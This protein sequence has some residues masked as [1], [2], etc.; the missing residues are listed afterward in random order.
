VLSGK[1]QFGIGASELALRRA[2]GAPIV[3]LAT[4][5]QHSP[6]VLLVARG[7][8]DTVQGLAGKRIMLMPHE[9]ELYAYLQREGVPRGSFTEVRHSFVPADLIEGRVDA[10]SGYSTD[11]PWNLQQAGFAYNVFTPRAS[12]VDFYG[13]TLFTTEAVAGRDRARAEAFRA[14]SLRGWQYAMQHPPEIAD[15]ILARY[16]RRHPREHL[17]F[18]AEEM[19]RLMQPQL[20]EI[21]HMNPG[22]WQHIAEVYAELGMLPA[23]WTLDGF[24]WEPRPRFDLD[25]MLRLLAGSLLIA[26]VVAYFALRQVRFN[27]SLR[28]VNER[29]QHQLKEIQDLHALLEQQLVRDQ[30]TGLY[31]RRYLDD[32]MTRELARAARQGYPV[33]LVMIDLDHFKRLNDTH[34]HQAGD[35]V[36]VALAEQLRQGVR[37]GDLACRWG[38]E[39]FVLLLPNMAGADASQRADALRAEFGRRRLRYRDAEF[40]ATFSAGVA[41]YPAHAQGADGLLRAADEALYRAKNDGR[42]CVRAAAAAPA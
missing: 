30:L 37:G 18:E 15:L 14:A 39:E 33:S 13:D 17:L 26:A 6:L 4:V 8:A 34:G 42:D 35:A 36:L 9:T 29:M 16:S 1:A 40:C 32:A 27:R 12:G 11:E 22:R 38:G 5:L 21:G 2:K 28:A 24:L 7:A 41:S 3:A 20:I 31:N 10:V 25:W 19:R 23:S